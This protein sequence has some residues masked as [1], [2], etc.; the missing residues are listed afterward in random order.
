MQFTKS[1]LLKIK[2]LL[3]KTYYCATTD[4]GKADKTCKKAKKGQ[5]EIQI[6]ECN[7]MHDKDFA[8]HLKSFINKF[9]GLL[10]GSQFANILRSIGQHDTKLFSKKQI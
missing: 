1:G 7:A 4:M 9:G 2:A 5:R 6:A 8:F 3:H 10:N